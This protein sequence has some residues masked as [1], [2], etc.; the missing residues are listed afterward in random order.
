M[1]TLLK[2]LKQ[3]S[4]YSFRFLLFLF[5]LICFSFTVGYSQKGLQLEKYI[6][7]GGKE[8]TG[9][10]ESLIFDNV[11]SILVKESNIQIV[12]EGFP[13]KL[14]TDI[15]SISVLNT[16]NSI[17][18]TVKILQ[19]N[20]GNESEKSALRIKM[21]NLKSFSNLA[22]IFINSDIPLTSEEVDLM[23]SGFEEGDIILLYQ[24]NSNF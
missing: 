23:V 13:Q 10:L 17:F 24:F 11:P 12:G 1:I 2:F 16:E 15:N 5:L 4:S 6:N 8:N 7:E 9:F 3:E 14:T 19:I 20:L 22:Y 18:R 21:E